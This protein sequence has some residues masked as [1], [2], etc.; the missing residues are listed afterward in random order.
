MGVNG[1]HLL[2]YSFILEA[3][4]RGYRYLTAYAHRSVIEERIARGE[5]IEIACKYNPDRY[6]Y[7]RYDLTKVDELDI[8]HK[9]EVVLKGL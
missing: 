5:P 7:Y 4:R 8:K 3:K 6:D 1:G 9:I 2:R